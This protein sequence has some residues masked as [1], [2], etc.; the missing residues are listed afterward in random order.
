MPVSF[1]IHR[2]TLGDQ[3]VGVRLEVEETRERVSNLDRLADPGRDQR[4]SS[5]AVERADWGSASR[6]M[7]ERSMRTIAI[8]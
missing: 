8:D 4:A 1:E 5:G 2:S 7:Q 3:R 6:S